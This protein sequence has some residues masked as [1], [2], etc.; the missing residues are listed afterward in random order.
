[1]HWE[2]IMTLAYQEFSRVTNFE[3]IIP[4]KACY[5]AHVL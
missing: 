1:M 5:Y 4:G 3:V 2:Q